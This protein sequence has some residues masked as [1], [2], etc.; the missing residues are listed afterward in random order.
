[1]ASERQIAANRRNATRSSG[2]RSAGGKKRASSNAYRYGLFSRRARAAV[3]QE[4]EAFA[5]KIADTAFDVITLEHARI[6]AEAENE[7]VLIREA[8]RTLIDYT[9]IFGSFKTPRLFPP[10]QRKHPWPKSTKNRSTSAEGQ[11][12]Q[13]IEAEDFLSTTPQTELERSAAIGHVL[14]ELTKLSLYEKRAAGRRD[15]TIRKLMKIKQT[16]VSRVEE[17]D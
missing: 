8:K 17:K 16:L 14:S 13:R 6:V 15:R 4:M 1:M 9:D 7:L 3:A 12:P 11:G 5:R 2:P 10:D